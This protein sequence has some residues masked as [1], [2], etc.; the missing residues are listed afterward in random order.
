MNNQNIKYVKLEV[1][2]PYDKNPRINE[3]S[4]PKVAESIKQFGFLQPIV[5]DSDGVILAGH[6]RYAASKLLGLAEVPVIYARNLSDA[7]AKAFRL[8]DNK[9]AESSKWDDYLLRDELVDLA[10]FDFDMTNFGFDDSELFRRRAAWKHL[11][12]RCGLKK[13]IKQLSN[14]NIMVT[15]FFEV[16]KEGIPITKIKSDKNNVPIFA[17]CLWDFLDRTLSLNISKGGWCILTP[18][19][20]RHKTGF[21]FATAI[22]RKTAEFCHLPF[23]EDAFQLIIVTGLIRILS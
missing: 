7:Q 2:K 11:E 15:T 8:A 12:K 6:T 16:G 23:Y 10:A 4:I 18:P 20:R 3:N 13:K 19:R 1:I 21:H 22:C 14:G 17:E 9:V 5:V